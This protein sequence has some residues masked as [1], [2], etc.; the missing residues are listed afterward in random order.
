[1]FS[2]F[3]Q[4]SI[5][6]DASASR[7]AFVP[8][9]TPVKNSFASNDD[10]NWWM[11]TLTDLAL[12]LLGFLLVWYLLDMN[13]LNATNLPATSAEISQKPKLPPSSDPI[14]VDLRDWQT[15]REEMQRFVT[16]IGLAKDVIVESAPNEIVVSLNDTVPFD[17][18][19]ADLREEAIPFLQKV[20]EV[21]LN[22][23]ALSLEVS[24]HTD[25]VYI[26]NAKFPSNWEL[27]TARASRVARYLIDN[28]FD[29]SRISVR[30]YANQRRRAPNSTVD[31]RGADSRRVEIRVY[32]GVDQNP[33][34]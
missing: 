21:V 5:A 17:S 15:I 24:G 23:D 14:H 22:G 2:K 25:N 12:L 26:S 31:N 28:G 6:R 3:L 19:K 20:V 10:A 32:R 18:G 33:V 16:E 1:M 29:S 8:S 7:T 30:G 27:S 9:V 11:V 4:R 13:N 34:R